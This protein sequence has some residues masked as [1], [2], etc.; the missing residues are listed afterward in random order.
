MA[1]RRKKVVKRK[2][3]TR[4]KKVVRKKSS[5]RKWTTIFGDTF[6]QRKLTTADIKKM[7]A[8]HD[9]PNAPIEIYK[10]GK[11]QPLK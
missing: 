9:L 7:N 1:K 5:M 2:R 6:R 8:G 11:W 10:N 3:V 4:R